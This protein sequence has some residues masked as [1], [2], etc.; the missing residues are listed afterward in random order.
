MLGGLHIEITAVKT[1][2]DLL[3]GSG[4]CEAIVGSGIAGEGKAESFIKATHVSRTRYMHQVSAASL[5]I[6]QQKAYDGYRLGVQQNQ[7]CLGFDEWCIQMVAMYPLFR[8]WSIV[9]QMELLIL[10]FVRSIRERNFL[11]YLDSLAELAPWF[12]ALNHTNYARWLPVHIHDMALLHIKHPD[13]SKEFHAGNFTQLKTQRPFSAIALDQMHE[14]EN[15]KVKGDGGAIGLTEDQA[16][17]QRWMI[18]GPEI[19]RLT[20]E[21]KGETGGDHSKHHD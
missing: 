20:Q 2:G 17:L 5:Y 8:F 15:A 13:I 9:L 3:D 21:F 18:A 11:L 16:A 14:Q 4:W 1:K 10:M 6:L 7:D 12:F 19:A